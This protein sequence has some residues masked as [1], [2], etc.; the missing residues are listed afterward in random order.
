[1]NVD[2]RAAYFFFQTN[3]QFSG[4]GMN[5]LFCLYRFEQWQYPYLGS[6]SC[7]I[8]IKSWMYM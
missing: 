5:C 7:R 1:M 8:I 3:K 4:D 6:S 2:F